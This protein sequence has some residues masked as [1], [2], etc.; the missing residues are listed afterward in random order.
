MCTFHVEGS[1]PTVNQVFVFGSNLAGRHGKGSALAARQ[2][3]GAIYGQGSGR[4]GMSYGIPTK[5]GRPGTWPLS[6]PRAT[7][8]LPVIKVEIDKFIQ[9]AKD[10]PELQ[11]FVVRLG[12]ALATHSNSDIAPMFNDAPSNCSFSEQWREYMVEQTNDISV[13]I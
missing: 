8:S 5:D 9:Y 1:A 7:L 4:Q 10:N 2:K 12:C 3:Y 6:D 13:S 11:F